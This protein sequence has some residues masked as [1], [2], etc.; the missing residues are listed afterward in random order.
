MSTP[1]IATTG[2]GLVGG[3]GDEGAGSARDS[4]QR[5]V[6]GTATGQ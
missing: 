1:R 5:G 3:C 6:G 2:S 4:S